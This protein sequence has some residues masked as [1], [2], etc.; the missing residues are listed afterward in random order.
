MPAVLEEVS[1]GVSVGPR[2]LGLAEV[3]RLVPVAVAR[4]PG[5]GLRHAEPGGRGPGDGPLPD[6]VSQ[7]YA[8]KYKTILF[9][10]HLIPSISE[11]RPNF[12]NW[13][14]NI[15]VVPNRDIAKNVT[16]H[17]AQS[18]KLMRKKVM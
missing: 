15:K 2:V 18:A 5:A 4:V 14:T 12:N 6:W 13:R 8:N 1:G 17:A 9:S 10:I 7:I 16:G 3:P 11:V